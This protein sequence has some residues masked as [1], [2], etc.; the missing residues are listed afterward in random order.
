MESS[1]LHTD[2][3]D[4]RIS[5]S[6]R[7][8]PQVTN[9]IVSP[10]KSVHPQLQGMESIN[11]QMDF[12]HRTTDFFEDSSGDESLEGIDPG[13]IAPDIALLD[14]RGSA[15]KKRR[16]ASTV[17]PFA[18]QCESKSGNLDPGRA[19][20]RR[21]T[22]SATYED[23]RMPDTAA[24]SI[25]HGSV[26]ELL[27]NEQKRTPPSQKRA[28][29]LASGTT[30]RNS[31]SAEQAERPQ[32][33]AMPSLIDPTLGAYAIAHELTL[34][35]LMRNTD[36]LERCRQSIALAPMRA[37]DRN[38]LPPPL[39]DP[40]SPRTHRFSS[41]G[42]SKKAVHVVPPP[43]DTSATRHSLPADLVRT[44]YPFTPD[45]TR[46]KDFIHSSSPPATATTTTP[47]TESILAL[48]IR[49]SNPNSKVRITSLTI[50]ASNDY[51][52]VRGGSLGAKERHFRA[53]DFDDAE[54]FHELR[55][56]YRE[57][58]GPIR[59]I[60]A[61]SLKR[62]AVSGPATK[63]A[64]VGYGWR[65]PRVLA[66]KGLS[67]TSSEQQIL[68]HYQR[69]A[70][71]RS[72]YAFVQWAHRL[73]AASPARTLRS[74]DREAEETRGESLS[75]INQPEGLEFV[76]SW[77]VPRILV[78]LAL[79][80]IFSIAAGLLWTFLG[81]QTPGSTPSDGGFRDAGDR[82]ATGLL[83]GICVLVGGLS[84]MTGWLGVSW[85]VM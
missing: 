72:R 6:P 73:T 17:E 28:S 80:F 36:A 8:S 76:V 10:V 61:R 68:Q 54:F 42:P 5:N 70:L 14:R 46:R 49:R 29:R 30:Y 4:I 65:S 22:P 63:A 50:P 37:G 56:C 51:T 11:C 33:V 24:S 78:V 59:F 82:L 1:F 16:T 35:S 21:L 31:V 84:G 15:A 47:N 62:I 18:S 34:D 44:P 75:Q 13:T 55:R 7:R 39:L 23:T 38:S 83:I 41:I 66:Y 64:D 57:L 27:P 12:A 48:S 26:D 69:P 45:N 20:Y 19:G 74:E 53:L 9:G 81:K 58:S 67:D 77:S 25:F 3:E 2:D 32:T 60:S 43:I 52:A 40:R 71:G 79:A 85:L